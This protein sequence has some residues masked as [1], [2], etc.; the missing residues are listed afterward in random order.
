MASK[1]SS[2]L[3]VI[4]ASPVLGGEPQ[5]ASAEVRAWEGTLTIPTYLWEEDINPK[6]WALEGGA[7]LSTTVQARSPTPT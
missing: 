6:F 1:I 2:L 3:M 4:I 7:K 5:Q